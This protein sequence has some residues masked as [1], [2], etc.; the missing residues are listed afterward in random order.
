MSESFRRPLSVRIL[1]RQAAERIVLSGCFEMDIESGFLIALHQD[2]PLA[3]RS[4]IYFDLSRQ[5]LRKKMS[6]MAATEVFWTMSRAMY[7]ATP[8]RLYNAVCGIPTDG[9]VF[10]EKF[11]KMNP[12]LVS[13]DMSKTRMKDGTRVFHVADKHAAEA[14]GKGLNVLLLDD[15][16]TSWTVKRAARREIEKVGH[17][18]VGVTIFLDRRP[19]PAL[20]LVEGVPVYSAINSHEMLQIALDYG[21]ITEEQMVEIQKYLA[22]PQN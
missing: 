19:E 11:L 6:P 12:A 3:P 9:K 10:A 16:A 8:R 14:L 18:V 2:N 21:R 20:N 13:I 5:N 17:C 7:L 15:L 4:P 22:Q 1:A